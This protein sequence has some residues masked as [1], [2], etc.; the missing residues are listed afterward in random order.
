MDCAEYG[1]LHDLIYNSSYRGGEK[2]ART[3]FHQIVAGAEYL[4]SNS[5]AHMDL[6]LS[7]IF[8]DGN[9]CMKIGDFDSAVKN[10]QGYQ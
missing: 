2:L 4:H 9:C 1:N 8:V 3:I 7:N 10:G 6:K 5:I